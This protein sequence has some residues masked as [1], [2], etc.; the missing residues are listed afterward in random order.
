MYKHLV[1][2]R[3]QVC[4][5]CLIFLFLGC[6][7]KTEPSKPQVVRKKIIA[8]ARPVKRSPKTK[9]VQST[10]PKASFRP[11]SAVSKTPRS[12]LAVK[13]KSSPDAVKTKVAPP[14]TAIADFGPKSDTSKTPSVR[15]TQKQIAEKSPAPP[16]QSDTPSKTQKIA[17]PSPKLVAKTKKKATDVQPTVASTKTVKI[18]ETDKAPTPY[19]PMGK[20]DPFEPLFKEKPA[21]TQAAKKIKKRTPRTPLEKIDISQLKLVGIVLASSGNK[22]LVQEASGKG[23]IIKKG[24]YIG[25]NSGKVVEI[26]KDNVIIEE[27]VEDVL[28]KVTTRK[29]EIRLPKPPGE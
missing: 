2:F 8:K 3:S 14:K 17:A 29:K 16:V 21:V 24:T 22:A 4:L 20:I 12:M 27:E 1:I 7:N 5:I 23:Y 11:K 9:A 10:R 26:Q 13:G 6:E 19:N 25:L 15:E 18:L 28:G